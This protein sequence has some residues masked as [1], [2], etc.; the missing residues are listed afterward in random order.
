MKWA[1]FVLVVFIRSGGGFKVPEAGGDITLPSPA[2]SV[3][4]DRRGKI[5]RTSSRSVAFVLSCRLWRTN[6]LARSCL[7]L[8]SLKITRISAVEA[9]GR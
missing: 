3:D 5:L 1:S 7:S 8:S 2:I 9:D 6:L 4:A